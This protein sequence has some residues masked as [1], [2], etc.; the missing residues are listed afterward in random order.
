MPLPGDLRGL[1][2]RDLLADAVAHNP[3]GPAVITREREMTYAELDDLSSRAAALWQSMGVGKGD[4][5]AMIVGNR[6]EFL[7][8]WFGL[9]K[10]GAV[11]AAV[12]TRW[13]RGEIEYAVGKVMPNY[14][15]ADDEFLE[16]ARAATDSDV[17]V[18]EEFLSR[19]RETTPAYDA[20]ELEAD[21]LISLIFTSGTTGFPKAVQQTHGNYVMTGQAY[22]TW[23]GLEQGDRLYT[24]MPLYHL[25]SQAYLTMATLALHGAMVLVPKFSASRFW[26]D[27]RKFRV[28]TFSGIPA[29][30]LILLKLPPGPH[31]RDHEVR[32]VYGYADPEPRR[33]FE[34]RLGVK[35]IS[36]F[37]MSECT[38]GA[39]WPR[40]GTAPLTSIGLPRVH[41]HPEFVNEIKVV[42]DDGREVPTGDLGELIV[43][44]PGLAHGY[45]NDPELT[46]A[47]FKDGWLY[48]GDI[49]NVDED[50]FLF[51]L[52]R[53]KDVLRKKGE[54]V[55]SIEVEGVINT[56]PRVE[57]AA[58]VGIPAE[59]GEDE[60]VA[61][62]KLM[63]G[64][65]VEPSELTDLCG[66]QLA[67][68]KVPRYVQFVDS[69]PKTGSGKIQKA[70]LRDS[71]VDESV[72]WDREAELQR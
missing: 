29:V 34:A 10:I 56:H 23:L 59:L 13:R 68:F 15:L 62:V 43:R 6:P 54:N 65:R 55:S 9:I 44:N 5:V 27:I 32:M 57:E 37:G 70:V 33:E 58:L 35:T 24:F 1:N 40:T 69:F 20:P 39:M 16:E 51:F 67:D 38:F 50:G 19:V 63:D 64:Q 36:G 71:W 53:K 12:N 60:L 8:V 14:L 52:D 41:P 72:W 49:G 3:D 30:L 4:R 66:A 26:D 46:D 7:V 2:V 18:L 11:L 28:N 17:V 21:D 45:F 31:E 61:F 48:S 42:D 25:N 22:P 47:A